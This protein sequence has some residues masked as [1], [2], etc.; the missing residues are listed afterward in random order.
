[1]IVL[2]LVVNRAGV[3]SW[4]GE[5]VCRQVA[6]MAERFNG[7]LFPFWDERHKQHLRCRAE[8]GKDRVQAVF[9]LTGLM[10]LRK[11]PFAESSVSWPEKRG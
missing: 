10:A 4:G 5:I 7:R 2:W 1:M 11:G 6:V 8:G 9:F 3:S